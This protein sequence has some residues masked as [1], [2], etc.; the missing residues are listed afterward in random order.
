MNTFA[1]TMMEERSV[2]LIDAVIEETAALIGL[3]DRSRIDA[4]LRNLREEFVTQEWQLSLLGDAQWREL[5]VPIGL[6]AGIR[7]KYLHKVSASEPHQALSPPSSNNEPP[8]RANRTELPRMMTGIGQRSLQ[9]LKKKTEQKSGS[10]ETVPVAFNRSTEESSRSSSSSD[11]SSQENGIQSFRLDEAMPSSALLS[12]HQRGM[13]VENDD[14]P[15]VVLFPSADEDINDDASN[16][17]GNAE[18]TDVEKPDPPSLLEDDNTLAQLKSPRQS[19]RKQ[20]RRRQKRGQ[21]RRQPPSSFWEVLKGYYSP[22]FERPL[23]LSVRF[24]KAMLISKSSEELKA[25]T[26][27]FMELA[28]L[29]TAFLTGASVEMWVRTNTRF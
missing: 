25:T 2:S 9:S 16:K 12:N 23:C 28:L 20:Q 10:N 15:V 1:P 8:Q 3:T 5:G 18:G 21:R 27:L 26:L 6:T 4:I 17:E 29:V 22:V 14:D 11:R 19:Q 24:R 13:V 7:K